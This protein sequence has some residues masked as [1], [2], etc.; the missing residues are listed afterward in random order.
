MMN[1][2]QELVARHESVLQG[3]V[4]QAKIPAERLRDASHYAVFSGGKRIRPLLVY[5][6]GELLDTPL[7]VLDIIAVAIELTHSYSL[8]H[9]D[10]PSMDNDDFRRGKPTCHRAYD[11]AT[12]ILVGDGLQALAIDILLTE[13][14]KFLNS[15]QAIRITKELVQS[16]GL[17]GMVSGQSL[18][19]SELSK[20][21]ISEKELLS[22]HSL[23]TGKLIKACVR[24]VLS[25]S[26][27]SDQAW[28]CLE[29]YAQNLGLAFQMQDDY[30]D[31]YAPIAVLGK[32]GSSDKANQKLTF[33]SLYDQK[34]LLE[35]IKHY[36]QLAKN[37]LAELH[38]SDV[39]Q[40]TEYLEKRSQESNV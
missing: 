21:N 14:P 28:R 23:K 36:F 10:L 2:V 15:E 37:A 24:M 39:L 26:D 20:R 22:I 7:Q 33:A 13:L 31:S 40:F 25:A 3:F 12:A 35:E 29:S 34:A 9:D 4:S 16:S 6:C 1:K 17:A 19:L 30:L 5:L 18:D 11:E 27:A 32:G 38:A 8:V